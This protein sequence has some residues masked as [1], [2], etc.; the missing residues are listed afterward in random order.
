VP[1]DAP[2]ASTPP[3]VPAAAPEAPPAPAR[4]AD[5]RP[6]AAPP[7]AAAP[8]RPPAHAQA[9][10]S[11][12]RPG[13]PAQA[14]VAAASS[15]PPAPAPTPDR[16]AEAR[17]LAGYRDAGARLEAAE[18]W[19]AA[20][21]EYEQA[22]AIDPHVAFAL[23]G[24]E[25]SMKRAALD[26]AID[27]HLSRPDRL[28]AAAVGREAE[29][30]LERARRAEARGPK[31]EARAAA[32]EAALARARTT[33]A[34]VIASDGLTEITLSRVGAL[35]ALTEKRLELL[36]GRYTVT[37][38]RRGYRDVRRDFELSPD[39]PR[40]TVSLRCEERVR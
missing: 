40:V 27:F 8:E 14:A 31:L 5:V 37:G 16:Q 10:G 38:S 33:I 3:A 12:T 28:S 7:A 39:A 13:A 18:S 19:H 17:A 15:E 34:V 20:R 6:E 4:D 24:R 29:E 2:A 11:S 21:H 35:G 23:E 22:L 32:L 30:L 36:P 25:R 9:S 1:P 26:D